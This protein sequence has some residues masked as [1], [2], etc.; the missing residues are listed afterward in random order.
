MQ[1]YTCLVCH[2]IVRCSIPHP[3]RRFLSHPTYSTTVQHPSEMVFNLTLKFQEENCST[4]ET[5]SCRPISEQVCNK[6]RR[7]ELDL[8]QN[9]FSPIDWWWCHK[10]IFI[11]QRGCLYKVTP[12]KWGRIGGSRHQEIR[13]PLKRL[14]ATT[15]GDDQY[16]PSKIL[17]V[18][19]LWSKL[20]DEEQILLQVQKECGESPLVTYKV[21]SDTLIWSN[22][23]LTW[24][25]DHWRDW[26]LHLPR[27]DITSR[28]FEQIGSWGDQKRLIATTIVADQT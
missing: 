21:R 23:W 1:N 12:H 14:I 28:W 2:C 25:D 7:V 19:F 15:T 11:S 18:I 16:L 4:V 24:S 22:W 9:P 27:S 3:T 5:K 6:G 17:V 13:C 8:V 20:F 10:L 26:L